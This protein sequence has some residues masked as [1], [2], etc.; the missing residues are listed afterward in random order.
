MLV[1]VLSSRSKNVGSNKKHCAHLLKV[2]CF[3]FQPYT[4][5]FSSLIRHPATSVLCFRF[6]ALSFDGTP[7]KSQTNLLFCLYRRSQT[8]NVL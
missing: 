7:E 4:F 3:W 6:I 2:A 8:K 5:V 1:P